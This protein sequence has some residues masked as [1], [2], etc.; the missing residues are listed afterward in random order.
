MDPLPTIYENEGLD[1]SELSIKMLNEHMDETVNKLNIEFLNISQRM[2]YM[3]DTFDKLYKNNKYDG[4][5]ML[6]IE[7]ELFEERMDSLIYRYQKTKNLLKK[8]RLIRYY[9]E[10][11]E[12]EK[13]NELRYARNT[14]AHYGIDST[15]DKQ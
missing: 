14:L 13:S 2:K 5:G 3:N 7:H 4:L 12:K 11:K 8:G 10:E 9:T 15:S 1:Y 6:F